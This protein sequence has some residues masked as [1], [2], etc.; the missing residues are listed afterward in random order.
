ML[1]T[2]KIVLGIGIVFRRELVEFSDLLNDRC[3][4]VGSESLDPAGDK[5]PTA[6]EG[7]AEV[8][9]QLGDRMG[10]RCLNHD[11]VDQVA[12]CIAI[13][14]RHAI[15]FL[16]RVW[17]KVAFKYDG[18]GE[19]GTYGIGRDRTDCFIIAFSSETAKASRAHVA[20]TVQ[21]F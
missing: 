9:I 13:F 8:I 2:A 7:P 1:K 10:L 15:P 5:D 21:C 20:N 3:E 16:I 4:G 17:R 19:A 12:L 14:L 6:G 11:V 18:G